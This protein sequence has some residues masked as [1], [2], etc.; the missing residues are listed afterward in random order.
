M[1]GGGQQQRCCF[2]VQR[3]MASK[4]ST[5][6]AREESHESSTAAQHVVVKRARHEETKVEQHQVMPDPT[7]LTRFLSP[8]M[9]DQQFLDSFFRKRSLA[10]H[11]VRAV[12]DGVVSLAGSPHGHCID[13]F[14]ARVEQS[15]FAVLS[16]RTCTTWTWKN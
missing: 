13:D 4:G 9:G 11:G 3:S 1:G 5:K 10:I 8:I 2:G 6:R 16:R 12:W 15:G 7:L 14:V